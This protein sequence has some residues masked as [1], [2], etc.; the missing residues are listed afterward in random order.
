MKK[1]RTP[2]KCIDT[3]QSRFGPSPE[4]TV[5]KF[6]NGLVNR[7]EHLRAW[8]QKRLNEAIRADSPDE[9][10]RGIVSSLTGTAGRIHD[11]KITSREH[12]TA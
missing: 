6:L 10:L 7:P 3:L 8:W 2:K 11:H 12:T 9:A 5:L 1:R 4:V